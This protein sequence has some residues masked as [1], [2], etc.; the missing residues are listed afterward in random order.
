M[1]KVPSA[2]GT[3]LE[4]RWVHGLDVFGNAQ[5]MADEKSPKA[6]KNKELCF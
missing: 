3:C 5:R 6:D 4:V 2:I 1:E